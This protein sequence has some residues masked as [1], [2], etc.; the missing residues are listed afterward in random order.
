MKKLVLILS[1]ALL[2]TSVNAQ[3]WGSKKVSGNGNTVTDTRNVSDY[4]EVGVAGSFDVI[5]VAGA[6]GKITV[7]AEENLQE[8]IITEVKGDKLKIYI[9]DGVSLKT[10][11]NKGI[12]IT[13]PFRELEEVN[14]AGS[15]DVI[16][17]DAI[18]AQDFKCSV[19]GSGDMILEVNAQDVTA[20]VA[21]SGDLS[22]SGSTQKSHL[23]VAGS[24]DLHA[25]DL[26][27]HDADA[28]IAGSGDISVYCNG[29]TLK[30]TV[31]G[32]GDIVYSG[33]PDKVDSKVVGSGSVSN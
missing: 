8:Y 15:G 25:A 19:S 10:S 5:L 31:A 26:K 27:S 1:I 4:D 6:E 14:L 7:E 13:V 32:S 28:S 30:A 2:S 12:I 24:G 17:K 22:L 21:G 9:E 3:W 33:K 11:S 20:A 23:K 18:N 29:G 16:T